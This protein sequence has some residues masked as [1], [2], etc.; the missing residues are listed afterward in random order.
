M[1]LL[2]AHNSGGA[3]GT[4]RRLLDTSRSM[5]LVAGAAASYPLDPEMHQLPEQ[6]LSAASLSDSSS[7]SAQQQWAAAAAALEA[8]SSRPL[9]QRHQGKHSSGQQ[10]QAPGSASAT[11]GAEAGHYSA[12]PI[13]QQQLPGVPCWVLRSAMRQGPDVLP[14]TAEAAS[15]EVLALSVTPRAQRKHAMMMRDMRHQDSIGPVRQFA[16]ARR[17]QQRG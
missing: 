17:Q 14:E 4:S 3:M 2:A 8:R 1:A 16:L 10:Q 6:L 7:A 13:S 5:R 9:T 15:E 12:R 11:A